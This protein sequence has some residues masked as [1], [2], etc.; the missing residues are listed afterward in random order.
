MLLLTYP[1][2]IGLWCPIGGA[3]LVVHYWWCT[4]GGNVVVMLC[5]V[6]LYSK[7]E[8]CSRMIDMKNVTVQ[9]HSL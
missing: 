7:K 4:T 6:V 8:S 1:L 9:V 5:K 3:L 2:V